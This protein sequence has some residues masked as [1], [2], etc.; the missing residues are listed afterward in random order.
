MQ[1]TLRTT[2]ASLIDESYHRTN[3]THYAQRAITLTAYGAVPEL[4]VELPFR[5]YSYLNNYTD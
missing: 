2:L 5:N 3:C 1:M 4:I